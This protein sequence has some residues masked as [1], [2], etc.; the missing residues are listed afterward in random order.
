MAAARRLKDEADRFEAD[1]FYVATS[2]ER[3]DIS[4]RLSENQQDFHPND[5][6]RTIGPFTAADPPE[7]RAQ[8][9]RNLVALGHSNAN[10]FGN[11]FST[12]QARVTNP[13]NPLFAPGGGGNFSS[14]TSSLGAKARFASATGG[15]GFSQKCYGS[16]GWS[17]HPK[18]ASFFIGVG[19][20]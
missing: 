3:L 7:R 14:R 19:P 13:Q 5:L 1:P 18:A 10:R 8:D 11:L 6:Q 17:F 4:Q 12:L 9:L 15:S 20:I 2:K 16:F